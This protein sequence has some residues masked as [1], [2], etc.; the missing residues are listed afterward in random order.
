MTVGASPAPAD[1]FERERPRLVGIAYRMLGTIADA[2][3]VVQD[4]WIR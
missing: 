2:E 4:A 1:A 3:D